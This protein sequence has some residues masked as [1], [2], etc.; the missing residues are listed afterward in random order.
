MHQCTGHHH[1][2]VMTTAPRHLSP[3]F[4]DAESR[5]TSN[6]YGLS[7]PAYRRYSHT[8]PAM[9]RNIAQPTDSTATQPF[10]VITE[11]ASRAFC[12]TCCMVPILIVPSLFIVSC[13]RHLCYAT[14]RIHIVT[15]NR[16]ITG[17][18]TCCSDLCKLF[19]RLSFLTK[20]HSISN[21]A[22]CATG[23]HQVGL[24]Y[25]LNSSLDMYICGWGRT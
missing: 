20:T 21:K 24:R 23:K 25:V 14:T 3:L 22:A 10:S 8:P 16:K 12:T 4:D 18:M 19:T 11:D 7:M 6:V 9:D 5:G 1:S 17:T 15:H 2:S 13:T